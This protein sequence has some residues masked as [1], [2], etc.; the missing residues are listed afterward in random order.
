M[1]PTLKKH[2]SCR[3]S[4]SSENTAFERCRS[5]FFRKRACSWYSNIKVKVEDVITGKLKGKA[6]LIPAAN[7]YEKKAEKQ[8]KTKS[9]GILQE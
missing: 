8:E 9:S 7:L 2:C 5:T 3:L 4:G 1:F 6:A